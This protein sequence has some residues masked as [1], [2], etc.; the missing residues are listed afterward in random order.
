MCAVESRSDIGKVL[1]DGR[2]NGQHRSK[3]TR[4]ALSRYAHQNASRRND[5]EVAFGQGGFSHKLAGG[6]YLLLVHDRAV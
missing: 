4:L 5:R 1:V 6:G 3:P 2:L